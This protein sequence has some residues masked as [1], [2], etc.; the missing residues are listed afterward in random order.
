M[1]KEEYFVNTFI[2]KSKRERLLYEL[3]NIKKRQ[4]AISRFNH[5]C[6]MH[7]DDRKLVY[8]GNSIDREELLSY[9]DQ[10]TYDKQ[11]YILAYNEI[12]DQQM[13]DSESALDAVIGNGMA[14]IM[15]WDNLV[16]IECEQVQGPA[17]KYILV[18]NN[19]KRNRCHYK[20][21]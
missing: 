8:Q 14:A 18:E 21:N 5:R 19:K 7:I 15:I 9:I 4:D 2:I 16:I 12:Y 6:I 1:Q 3:S 13:F 20:N 11:C 17:D 10:Y